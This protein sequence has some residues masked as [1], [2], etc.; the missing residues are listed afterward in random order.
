[1]LTLHAI[2]ILNKLIRSTYRIEIGGF[3]LEIVLAAVSH[4][5]NWSKRVEF[6]CSARE[7]KQI[8]IK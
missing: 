3:G 7:D 2:T 5:W 6:E 1:M 8:I 4:V